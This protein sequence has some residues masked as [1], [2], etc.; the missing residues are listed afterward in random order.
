MR[1]KYGID[2]AQALQAQ[3][4]E[5][6]QL[7]SV[8]L[9]QQLISISSVVEE[10]QITKQVEKNTVGHPWLKLKNSLYE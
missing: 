5:F 7:I 2:L 8:V 3:L 4:S 1:V 6:K 9:I 10:Q